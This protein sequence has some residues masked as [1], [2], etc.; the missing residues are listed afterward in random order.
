VLYET[1]KRKGAD[2]DA[3]PAETEKK[4]IAG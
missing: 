2:S 3:A 1:T 4:K